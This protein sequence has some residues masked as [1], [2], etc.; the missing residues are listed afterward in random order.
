MATVKAGDCRCADGDAALVP[1]DRQRIINHQM[2]HITAQPNPDY[3]RAASC[4]FCCGDGEGMVAEAGDQVEPS[5]KRFDIAGDGVNDGELAA[6]DL[7]Y[8]AGRDS[9]SWRTC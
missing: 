1:I 3:G 9:R 4:R 8:P 2:Y 5:A 6:L 7:G